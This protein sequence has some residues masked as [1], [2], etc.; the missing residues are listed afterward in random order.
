[1][2]RPS[3]SR[4]CAPRSAGATTSSTSRRSACSPSSASSSAASRCTAAEA[5]CGPDA[6]DGIA[7]LADHSLLTRDGRRY[8]MLETVRE[9]ALE[10]T[11]VTPPPIRDRHAQA[12]AALFRDA[13]E[14]MSRRRAAGLAGA[15]GR[16]PRQHPRRPAPRD[17]APPTETRRSRWPRRCGATGSCAG[18][19]T[20]G[21]ELLD[22]TARPRERAVRAARARAQR[23]RCARRRAGRLRRLAW[24]LRGQRRTG[25]RDRRARAGG[26]RERQPRRPRHLRGR[27]RE[28]DPPV[29]GGGRG[30][31]RERRRAHPQPDA[32][33]PRP[34]P[35]GRRAPRT[36]PRSWSRRA[37]RSRLAA[38]TW[39]TSP[40][41]AAR[42]RGCCSTTDRERALA[43][44]RESLEIAHDARRYERDRRRAWRSPPRR[45]TPRTGAVLWGAADALRAGTGAIRQPDDE[46]WA[47]RARGRAA[48]GTRPGVRRGAARRRGAL[49]RRGD[50]A[51]AT[52]RRRRVAARAAARARP[53]RPRSA[54]S[55]RRSR[56]WHGR[57]G[58]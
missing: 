34:R 54:A 27:S 32:A 8:G 5:V 9:Y 14:G 16:R 51:R 22:A 44:L 26:T 23:R 45:P 38:A 46:I 42:S 17:R 53:P 2:T 30:R 24:P 21:R 49:R 39:R 52:Q 35:R 11:R 56:T 36:G 28:G 43:L 25:A 55:R 48:R 50:R 12:Y 7:A 58:C 6:L 15:A 31:A 41:P 13:E 47:G 33:E 19:S 1:M 10:Q 37:S 20:E 40:R 57:R 18:T 3:A 29:R 4:R